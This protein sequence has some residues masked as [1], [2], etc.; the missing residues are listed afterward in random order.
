MGDLQLNEQVKKTLT[1][2]DKELCFQNQLLQDEREY[3]DN[4]LKES[5]HKIKTLLSES[6]DNDNKIEQVDKLISERI[7]ID[8]KMREVDESIFK[9]LD[10]IKGIIMSCIN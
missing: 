9:F 5:D 8:N 7:D 4:K 2:L 1:A 6:I 10:D 3:F